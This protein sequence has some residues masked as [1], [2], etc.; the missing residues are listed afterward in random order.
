MST[1]LE[2][3][4]HF[5]IHLDHHVPLFSHGFVPFLLAVVNPISELDTNDSCTDINDPL[6]WDLWQIRFI[7]QVVEDSWVVAGKVHDVIE[8]QVLVLW[9]MQSL[10]GIVLEA[11]LLPVADISQKVNGDVLF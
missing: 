1:C 9:Y 6:L 2:L 5:G 4:C 3:G 10:D 7:G 8:R 11:Q